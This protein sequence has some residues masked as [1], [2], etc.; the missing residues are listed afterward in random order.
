MK[1]KL[2]L[3]RGVKTFLTLS[4]YYGIEVGMILL[5]IARMKQLG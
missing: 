1:R 5:F 2:R 3:K 4:L